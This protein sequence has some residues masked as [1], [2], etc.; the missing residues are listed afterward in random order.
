MAFKEVLVIT[1]DNPSE[2]EIIKHLQ[3]VTAHVVAGTNLFSDF[4]AGMSDIF[5]G[6]SGSY[7][8]QL[9]SIYSEA[10]ER[11]KQ[12]A[13]RLGQMELSVSRLI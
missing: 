10:I 6:R 4:F 12:E 11:I 8:K 2:G 5:G 7:K 13:K 1:T 9:S 3:P